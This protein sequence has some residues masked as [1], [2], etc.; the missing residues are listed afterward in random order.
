[1][2]WTSVDDLKLDDQSWHTLIA[3]AFFFTINKTT[4]GKGNMMTEAPIYTQ[5]EMIAMVNPV[6]IFSRPG[7]L[8]STIIAAGVVVAI[9]GS[10][11]NSSFCALAS[12]YFSI[13][14]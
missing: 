3:I 11:V 6:L 12:T 13:P 1:M 2:R 5:L 10:G 9:D 8:C 14:L 7:C 4:L